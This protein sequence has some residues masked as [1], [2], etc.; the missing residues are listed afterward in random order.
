MTAEEALNEI[1]SELKYYIGT[2][3]SQQN[4]SATVKRIR[5]GRATINKRNEFFN[6]FGYVYREGE[7]IKTKVDTTN[8][9]T[10]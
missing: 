1:T 6:E 3:Y 9:K 2:S 4:A 10:K 5:E 8:Y 7:W